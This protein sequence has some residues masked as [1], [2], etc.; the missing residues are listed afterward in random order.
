MSPKR[1]I[2]AVDMVNDIRS[3]M[4]DPELM[5][6]FQLSSSSLQ[7]AFRKL[8]EAE[9]ISPEEIYGRPPGTDEIVDFGAAYRIITRYE[10]D[11]PLSVHELNNT[12]STGTVKDISVNGVG[13]RGI[14]AAVDEIKTFIIPAD[15]LFGIE[16]VEFEAICRW[17]K[18]DKIE[19]ECSGGFEVLTVMKGNLKDLEMAIR[20]IPL[21]DRVALQKRS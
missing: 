14:E 7:W 15:E 3:G 1:R 12:E 11:I 21:E 10:L 6:K 13:I 2:R 20:S 19:G 17:V 4:T 16:R 18:R 8:L 9:A 5:E